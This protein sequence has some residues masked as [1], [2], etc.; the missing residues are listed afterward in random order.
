MLPSDLHYLQGRQRPS[1][2]NIAAVILPLAPKVTE[3]EREKEREINQTVST[4]KSYH[5]DRTISQEYDTILSQRGSFGP[6]KRV[7]E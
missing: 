2:S 6:S 3:R 4:L 5:V 7:R 1:S